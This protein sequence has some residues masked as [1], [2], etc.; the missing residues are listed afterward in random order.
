MSPQRHRSAQQQLLIMTSNSANRHPVS[1]RGSRAVPGCTRP[2]PAPSGSNRGRSAAGFDLNPG[3]ITTNGVPRGY[4][5][6]WGA[7]NAGVLGCFLAQVQLRC[8]LLYKQPRKQTRV[9]GR[10]TDG[11]GVPSSACIS[12]CTA[13]AVPTGTIV[14]Y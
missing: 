8:V 12:A 2:N 6:V 9:V 7:E 10:H 5:T 13:L 14:H 11:C 3:V 4:G 1:D